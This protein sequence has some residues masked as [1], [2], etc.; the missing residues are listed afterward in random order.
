MYPCVLITYDNVG[1]MS[2]IMIATGWVKGESDY[3]ETL[4]R[5]RRG[6]IP[7]LP[8]PR[9]ALM[10]MAMLLVFPN[11]LLASPFL[12]DVATLF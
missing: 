8:Y 6:S 2:N 11:A 3:P 4:E 5:V 12:E 7:T 1:N 10:R 9:P